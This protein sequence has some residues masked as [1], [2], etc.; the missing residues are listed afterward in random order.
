MPTAEA[1]LCNQALR[2]CG[3][4][5]QIASLDEQSAPARACKEFFTDLRDSLQRSRKWSF[6]R[7]TIELTW[8]SDNPVP[9]YAKSYRYPSEALRIW[10][11][12]TDAKTPPIPYEI[13]S[14]VWGKL[15]WTNVTDVRAEYGSRVERVELWPADFREMFTYRL[16]VA[17][18]PSLGEGDPRKLGARSMELYRLSMGEAATNE[19]NE[20]LSDISEDTDSIK[21]RG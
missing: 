16:A 19:A 21:A 9:E 15:I 2:H 14:D 10:R 20:E 17:I 1:V 11:L 6:T 3:V 4:G 13:A 18:M 8:M 5:I 12:F 7:K